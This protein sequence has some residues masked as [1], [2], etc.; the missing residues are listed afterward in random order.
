M[1]YG[2]ILKI[3]Y[4]LLLSIILTL[5]LSAC[6]SGS[7]ASFEQVNETIQLEIGVAQEV[8]T[9]DKLIEEEDNTTIKV[10]HELNNDIKS[11]T[12]LTGSAKLIRGNYETTN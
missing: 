9:G 7:S 4:L 2:K 5:L 6:G 3:K 12:L 1:R 10:V 11:V 8:S